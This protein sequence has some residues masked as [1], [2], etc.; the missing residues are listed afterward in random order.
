M[1]SQTQLFNTYVRTSKHFVFLVRHG[2]TSRLVHNRTYA[3][4]LLGLHLQVSLPALTFP[5]IMCHAHS[6]ACARHTVV[7]V[8]CSFIHVKGFMFGL[9]Q[10]RFSAHF[11]PSL[12]FPEGLVDH[13]PT[14]L[15]V[16]HTGFIQAKGKASLNTF[17][18]PCV[19]GRHSSAFLWLKNIVALH[20]YEI[21]VCCIQVLLGIIWMCFG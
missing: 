3:A 10:H 6:S 18:P 19:T 1:R 7:V 15:I 12:P 14:T 13:K 16:Q 11:S 4:K 2:L 17:Q 20:G 8:H 9:V 5:P 21:P